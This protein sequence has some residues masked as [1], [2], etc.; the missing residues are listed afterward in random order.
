MDGSPT[1][2]VVV[3]DRADVVARGAAALVLVGA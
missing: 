1:G 2:V 3:A